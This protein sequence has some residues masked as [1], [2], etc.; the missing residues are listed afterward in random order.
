VYC[1][2]GALHKP[3]NIFYKY[4]LYRNTIGKDIT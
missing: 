1:D 2:A 4:M 3:A